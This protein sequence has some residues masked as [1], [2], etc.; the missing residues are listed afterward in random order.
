[1]LCAS[2]K[3]PFARIV[4]SPACHTAFA[5]NAAFIKVAKWYKSNKAKPD[6]CEASRS[7]NPN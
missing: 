5:L 2:P 3:L 6:L 1:M 4:V 7:I